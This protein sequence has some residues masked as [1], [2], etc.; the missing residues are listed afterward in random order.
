VAS[1]GWRVTVE[2]DSGESQTITHFFGSLLSARHVTSLFADPSDTEGSA[3][4][5][6]LCD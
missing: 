1:G 2:S 3:I 4:Y 5:N 6:P